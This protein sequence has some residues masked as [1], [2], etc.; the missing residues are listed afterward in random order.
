[1]VA[2]VLALETIGWICGRMEVN[3]VPD[4]S[5]RI[6]QMIVLACLPLAA[7]GISMFTARH[8]VDTALKQLP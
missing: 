7:A 4:F 2:G 3:L 8:T 6:W 5:L 1:M